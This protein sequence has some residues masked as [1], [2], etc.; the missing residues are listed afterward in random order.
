MDYPNSLPSICQQLLFT[1]AFTQ[2]QRTAAY[3]ELYDSLRDYTVRHLSRRVR[4][5]RCAVADRIGR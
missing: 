5:A 3:V 1:F 4:T 2:R